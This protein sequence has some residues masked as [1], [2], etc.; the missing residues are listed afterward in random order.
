MAVT[1]DGSEQVLRASRN[2]RTRAFI[3]FPVV[4]VVS[5][6]LLFMALRAGSETARVLGGL[7][8][9]LFVVGIWYLAVYITLGSTVIDGQGITVRSLFVR[10]RLAWHEITEI[11]IGYLN[12]RQSYRTLHAHLRM[13]TR[14]TL[15]G[16]VA[17]TAEESHFQQN[18]D[19]VRSAQLTEHAPRPLWMDG[20]E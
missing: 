18:V 15:N 16:I 2:E 5:T 9:A 20:R 13:G 19:A 4:A 8:Y 17:R 3:A 14:V 10:R 11:R 6:P 1:V 7:G 12:R